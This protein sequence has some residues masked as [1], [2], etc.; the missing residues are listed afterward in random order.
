[1]S[2]GFHI[3]NSTY[4]TLS[5]TLTMID[6]NPSEYHFTL[7]LDSG[8]NKKFLVILITNHNQKYRQLTDNICAH[9]S[10]ITSIKYR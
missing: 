1:M 9:C 4:L 6:A 8:K 10:N 3:R 2:L 7:V 5:L